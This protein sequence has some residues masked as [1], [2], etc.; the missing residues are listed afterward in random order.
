MKKYWILL[1]VS[2]FLLSACQSADTET[3]TETAQPQTAD[4]TDAPETESADAQ[5][6]GA[7]ATD[8]PP[9]PYEFN[10][11]QYELQMM[12]LLP[13]EAV[14]KLDEP[15]AQ[16]EA[17]ALQ[18]AYADKARHI[19]RDAQLR[20]DEEM[21]HRDAYDLAA[22]GMTAIYAEEEA[23]GKGAFYKVEN[24][25]NTVWMLG[26]I[27][28]GDP[29]MYPVEAS[30]MRAFEESDEL[31]VE[32]HLQDPQVLAEVQ[33]YQVRDD[34]MTLEEE[35]GTERFERMLAVLEEF[36]MPVA[37][38]A[39]QQL[40]AWVMLNN[41]SMLPVIADNPYSAMTGIDMYFMTR[42]AVS[43]KPVISMETPEIQM[44][45]VIEY[46]EGE[47]DRLHGQIDEQ[48]DKLTDPAKLEE[49]KE[50]M[51]A[52]QSSWVEGDMATLEAMV[53][54]NPDEMAI[55][56]DT[57]DPLM[58]EKI[59]DMLE[60]DEPKTTFVLVGAGHLIPEGSVVDLLRA[61]GYEVE[62]LNE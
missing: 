45:T 43:G 16:E 40:P 7:E 46:Y 38:D 11:A 62:E 8:T 21:L 24:E 49:E 5:T 36:G 20:L 44:G 50:A 3:E 47:Q 51:R 23:G 26:S 1:M 35:L 58:T 25:G 29:A 48:L 15:I 32:I 9:A 54:A 19:G 33:K 31:H 14:P 4:T 59:I 52:M 22:D 34:G 56:T 12:G 37:R 61:Q 2:V 6:E 13:M 10:E 30:R 53:T 55:L 57:R 17:E 18:T 60:S 39:A 28:I 41:L 27:H 42:A